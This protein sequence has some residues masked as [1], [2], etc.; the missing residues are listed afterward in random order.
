MCRHFFQWPFGQTEREL[1][2]VQLIELVKRIHE[3]YF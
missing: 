3:E 1:N 2:I